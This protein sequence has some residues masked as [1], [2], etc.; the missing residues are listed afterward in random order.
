[1]FHRRP[2]N[3]AS[4]LNDLFEYRPRMSF[5]EPVHGDLADALQFG[6]ISGHELKEQLVLGR[7]VKVQTSS[8]DASGVG[9]ILKRCP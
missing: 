6:V 8:K 4:E 9:D 1:V 2:C 3:L 7:K 5:I